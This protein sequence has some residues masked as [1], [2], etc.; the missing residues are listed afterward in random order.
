MVPSTGL[1]F[2]NHSLQS[3]ITTLK[4]YSSILSRCPPLFASTGFGNCLAVM[5]RM[6]RW[7]EL[8]KLHSSSISYRLGQ[9]NFRFPLATSSSSVFHKRNLSNFHYFPMCIAGKRKF[10]NRPF[11]GEHKASSDLPANAICMYRIYDISKA[12]GFNGTSL[13]YA[14][15]PKLSKIK[16]SFGRVKWAAA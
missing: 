4:K 9:T 13:I 12:E 5:P 8:R 7:A 6:P 2:P 14:R 16:L 3:V 10:E 15:I 1:M 11:V